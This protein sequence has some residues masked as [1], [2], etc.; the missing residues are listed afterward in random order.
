MCIT[1]T[2]ITTITRR[3]WRIKDGE[4]VYGREACFELIELGD[5]LYDIVPYEQNPDDVIIWPFDKSKRY[6]VKSFYNILNLS[7]RGVELEEHR[8]MGLGFIW[9]ATVPSKLKFFGW[10]LLLDRLPTRKLLRRRGII[11]TT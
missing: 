3:R 8:K 9:G 1:T 6:S 10:R 2:T 4:E 11:T 7:I 5:L